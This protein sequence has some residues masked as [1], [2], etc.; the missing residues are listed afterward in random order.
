M[1]RKARAVFFTA[2][3]RVEYRPVKVSS[4]GKN[5]VLIK[6]RYSAISPGT[7]SMIYQGRFP[8]N[9][10][11]DPSIKSL[12]DNFAYPF[13]YGYALAGEVI[14]VGDG[15]GDEWLNQRVFAFH[16]HQNY[17]VVS[18]SDCWLIP[19]Q[20]SL[21]EAVFLPNVESALNF[22]MD[23]APLIGEKIMVI[24]LGVVG[25]LTTRLL[26]TLPLSD[27]IAVD[28]LVYRREAAMDSGATQVVDASDPASWQRLVSQLFR[29]QQGMDL[30]FELSG[31]PDGLNQAIEVSGFSGRILMGSWY[32][33]GQQAIEL[34][35]HFHRRRLRLLSS[36]VSSISPE[37]SGRWDKTRRINMAWQ[38]IRTIKPE[39]LITHRFAVEQCQEA[40][41]L[42]SRRFDG[43]LQVILEYN[44]E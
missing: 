21:Q 44:G 41:D 18:L 14:A 19:E 39:G 37:L 40:F 31:N 36:Q 16:P 10:P 38:L 23:A 42:V 20:M 6:T 22:V 11:Q 30:V 43:V 17:A 29:G 1:A 32:G 2:P 13:R 25:L 26:S 12:Q 3:H 34:G 35:G 5:Q 33:K 8:E 9:E 24:G 27:L 4:L 28:P 15:V 7:E